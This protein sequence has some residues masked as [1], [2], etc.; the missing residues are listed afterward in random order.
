[1]TSNNILAIRVN[2]VNL[3][4]ELQAIIKG[5]SC[6]VNKLRCDLCSLGNDSISLPL[7]YSFISSLEGS[8][9]I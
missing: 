8:L 7:L 9:V 3:L 4:V 1:M 5:W 6:L 2:L